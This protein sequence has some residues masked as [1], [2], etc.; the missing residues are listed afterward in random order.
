MGRPGRQSARRLRIASRNFPLSAVPAVES[1]L[2]G[3]NFIATP[4]MQ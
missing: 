4:F 1:Q 3:A 2:L